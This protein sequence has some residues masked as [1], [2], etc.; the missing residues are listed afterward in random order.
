MNRVLV[1]VALCAC[2]S[3][4]ADKPKDESPNVMAVMNELMTREEQ[5][6]VETAAYL[7][8]GAS[9]DD[10]HPATRDVQPFEPLPPAWAKLHLK[11]PFAKSRC[12]YA[13]IANDAKPG[14]I[15][16]KAGFAPPAGAWFYIVARCA[17]VAYFVSSIDNTIR[18]VPN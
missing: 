5:Y 2:G 3:K 17:D 18:K 13:V 7:A 10:V 12:G 14:A 15:A 4:E 1:A 9:E 8:T 11:L 16:Q 6:K